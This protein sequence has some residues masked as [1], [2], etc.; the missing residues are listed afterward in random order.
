VSG[1]QDTVQDESLFALDKPALI[2]L[3]EFGLGLVDVFERTLR[4]PHGREVFG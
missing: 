4:A 3:Q 1:R 2:R